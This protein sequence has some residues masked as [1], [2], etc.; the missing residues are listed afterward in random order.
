MDSVPRFGELFSLYKQEHQNLKKNNSKTVWDSDI[1]EAKSYK[2]FNQFHLKELV[3]LRFLEEDWNISFTDFLVEATGEDLLKFASGDT[4]NNTEFKTWTGF[5]ML[6]DLYRL[7]SADALAFSDIGEKRL[8]NYRQ[9]IELFQD[10]FQHL[11]E[12]SNRQKDFNQF[13]FIFKKFLNGEPSENFTIDLSSNQV[14]LD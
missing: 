12:P 5:D 2:D 3:R 6:F 10:K 7:R 8:D 9:I 14:P 13:C 1:L 4:K 11:K